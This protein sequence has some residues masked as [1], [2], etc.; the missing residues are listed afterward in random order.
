MKRHEE[1]TTNPKQDD[2]EARR[3]TTNPKQDDEEARRK[4]NKPEAEARRK[5]TI[6]TFGTGVSC[7][8]R[9]QREQEEGR[10]TSSSW[11]PRS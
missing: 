9:L 10:R 3:K 2:E 5:T 8:C 4:D 6:H 7:M 11:K 1:K